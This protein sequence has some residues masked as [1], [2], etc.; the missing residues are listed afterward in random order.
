MK[1]S[2]LRQ[3]HRWLGLFFSL[4]I[5]MSTLSGVIH[6]VMTRTQAPPPSARPSGGDLNPATIRISVPEAV[7]KLPADA[8]T[9]KAV[10]LRGISGS[11]WYQI[12]TAKG[13]GAYYINATDGNLDPTQD[14]L[15]AAE[16]ATAFLGGVTVRKTDFLTSFNGEYIN[17][18]RMLPVYRFDTGDDLDTRVYVSTTTGSV[19]RHTDRRRQFEANI[20]T[21]FHKFGFIPNKNLRDFVLTA[22]TAGSALAAIAGIGL[23]VV[24]RPRRTS[25]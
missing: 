16:I 25:K 20:F 24:T 13:Q 17:I 12:Y 9:V 21:Y 2:T 23:F 5:L 3:L 8:G 22:V 11:V 19:T 4:S 10:N 1:P 14:E 6:T 7:S 15:Y 18:F